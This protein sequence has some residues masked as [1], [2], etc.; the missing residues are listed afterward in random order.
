[1]KFAVNAHL[2]GRGWHRAL[3]IAVELSRLG[4]EVVI[5]TKEGVPE[6]ELARAAREADV[7]IILDAPVPYEL[8]PP[9]ILERRGAL[10]VDVDEDPWAL[11][12]DMDLLAG[13]RAARHKFADPAAVSRLES[14]VRAADLVTVPT[15]E[16]YKTLEQRGA[17]AVSLT[18]N[19]VPSEGQR[20]APRRG[21][22]PA[23]DDAP[24]PPSVLERAMPH[25]DRTR[26]GPKPSQRD[27]RRGNGTKRVI[28][29]TGNALNVPDLPPA[30]KAIR[31][32]FGLDPS[33]EVR[34][35]GPVNFLQTREWATSPKWS[36]RYSPFLAGTRGAPS[37]T[38]PFPLYFDA[39]EAMDPDVA[40]LPLRD[41]AWNRAKSALTLYSWAV[42][43]VAC[44]CSRT[45]PYALAEKEGFP[46]IFVEHGDV[47]AW[48]SALRA[49]L[50]ESSHVGFGERAREWVLERHSLSGAVDAWKLAYERAVSRRSV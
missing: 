22:P 25:R 26:T 3:G 9:Q 43:G 23:P 42:Q 32:G 13:A 30:L 27:L 18:T 50:Y 31:S 10:V 2:S 39:L 41:C 20:R 1:M 16:L 33:I 8:A 34:T 36:I 11:Q 7:L 6:A 14:W 44:I 49:I 19:C 4:H 47:S 45:G 5:L 35:L 46:A 29:W 24:T 38:V 28:G 40:I 15:V 21:A 12:A 37:W 48:K 17:R